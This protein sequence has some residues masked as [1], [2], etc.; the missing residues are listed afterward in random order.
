MWRRDDSTRKFSDLFTPDTSFALPYNAVSASEAHQRWNMIRKIKALCLLSIADPDLKKALGL[1]ILR[2][3]PRYSNTKAGELK[4]F[5]LGTH[6]PS[7]HLRHSLPC[8]IVPCPPVSFLVCY[9]W[10]LSA[11]RL[12][13]RLSSNLLFSQ[14]GLNLAHLRHHLSIDYV[15]QS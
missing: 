11:A 14:D 7:Y 6:R 4:R 5:I 12:L 8:L 13:G 9:M 15:P 2:V 3:S 10:N 1:S